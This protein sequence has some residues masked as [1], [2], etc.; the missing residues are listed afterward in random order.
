MGCFRRKDENKLPPQW[1]PNR[2]SIAGNTRDYFFKSHLD[3]GLFKAPNLKEFKRAIGLAP[4]VKISL[5]IPLLLW[6]LLDK[7]RRLK[8]NY[9]FPL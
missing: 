8:E 5:I 4:M 1:E 9:D 7:A 3:F 6:Q 2:V